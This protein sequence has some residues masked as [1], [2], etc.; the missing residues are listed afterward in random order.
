ML[1]ERERKRLQAVLLTRT[2]THG[3]RVRARQAL[4]A[5]LALADEH[6]SSAQKESDRRPARATEGKN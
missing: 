6:E 5:D 3:E 1:L 2:S 4:E